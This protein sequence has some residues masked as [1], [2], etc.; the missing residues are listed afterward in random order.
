MIIKMKQ[1]LYQLIRDLGYNITD[2]GNYSEEF[3]YLM[4][5]TG[6]DKRLDAFNVRMDNMEFILDIFSTYNGEK[7]ILDIVE[8]IANNLYKIKDNN[9]EVMY[10]AQRSLNILGDNTSGPV[11]KHGVVTYMIYTSSSL[12][13]NEEGDNSNEQG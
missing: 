6:D 1:Q 10:V 12:I 4:I 13:K 5:R 3:P 8:N 11:R 7:E 9:E 2:T